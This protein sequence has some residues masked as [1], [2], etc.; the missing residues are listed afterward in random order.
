[1]TK[2]QIIKIDMI[3]KNP[4]QPRKHFDEDSLQELAGS[5]KEH[6]LIQPITV[7][8][9]KDGFFTLISGERRLRALK[10]NGKKTLQVGKEILIHDRSN[11]SGRER[12]ILATI[13]N[14]QRT[15]LNP[16]ETASV[17]QQLMDE[18]GMA[19]GEISQ[20]LKKASTSIYNSLQLLQA[21]PEIQE[22]WA[23]HKITHEPHTVVAIL[24]LP[25]GQERVQL[26][27]KFAQRQ[28]TGKMIISACKRFNELHAGKQKKQKGTLAQQSVER[29][30]TKR[31]EWDALFQLGKVPPFPLVNDVVMQTCDDCSL[32]PMASDAVCGSCALVSFLRGLEEEVEHVA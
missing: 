31:P 7:E 22:L 4:K 32:R 26:C 17:Y 16:I 29:I 21:E 30:S 23:N 11:H 19:P 25:A 15:D 13:E 27:Q 12:L 8:P 14:I 18:Y 1:M 28:F 24:S 2:N 6:G 5:I 9:E 20:A 10:L 3:L